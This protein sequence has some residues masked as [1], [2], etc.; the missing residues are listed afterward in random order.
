MPS[1]PVIRRSRS[2]QLGT[3]ALLALADSQILPTATV[4]AGVQ[5]RQLLVDLDVRR[6]LDAPLHHRAVLVPDAGQQRLHGLAVDPEGEVTLAQEIRVHIAEQ[7]P[8]LGLLARQQVVLL[9]LQVADDDLG[10]VLSRIIL[11]LADDRHDEVVL[12]GHLPEVQSDTHPLGVPGTGRA[13]LGRVAESSRR[14]VEAHAEQAELA[15]AG[16]ARP[17]GGQRHVEV[18]EAHTPA[19]VAD[20]HLRVPVVGVPAGKADGDRRRVVLRR[21]REEVV[22]SVVDQ[23]GQALPRRELDVTEHRQQPRMRRDIDALPADG[24]FLIDHN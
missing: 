21:V 18:V 4:V 10:S 19:V 6:V 13:D 1:Q 11:G 5:R 3:A 15:V 16:V 12:G 22:E 14:D 20:P 7:V 8:D 2:S 17:S 9:L 23:L 24:D